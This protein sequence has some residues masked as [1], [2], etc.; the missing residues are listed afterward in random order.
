MDIDSALHLLMFE[1]M[2]IGNYHLFAKLKGYKEANYH[3]HKLSY[4]PESYPVLWQSQVK[5]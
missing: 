3:K 5:C 4:K 1:T 2:A